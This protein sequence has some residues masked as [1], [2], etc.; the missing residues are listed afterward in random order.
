MTRRKVNSIAGARFIVVKA[1]NE[2]ATFDSKAVRA[3]MGD[4]WYEA[5]QRDGT[6]TT[7]TV[8][9]KPP[10]DTPAAGCAAR[11]RHGACGRRGPVQGGC[12]KPLATV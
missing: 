1:V 5:R 11:R 6:R 12:M 4:D 3:E 7:Y 8:M 2:I 10:E 9:A